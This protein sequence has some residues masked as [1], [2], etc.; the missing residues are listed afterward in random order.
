MGGMGNFYEATR[1]MMTISV[2]A[3]I[4]GNQSKRSL[5]VEPKTTEI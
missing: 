5:N 1:I 2:R 4:L 3:V